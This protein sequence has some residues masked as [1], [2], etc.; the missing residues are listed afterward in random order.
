M[1]N[2]PL[3]Y[4]LAM[5][6]VPGI[7][8]ITARKLIAYVGSPE[9]VF[10]EKPE[11]LKRIPGVGAHLA[12]QVSARNLVAEAEAEIGRM[13]KYKI[14]SVYYRD[15]AYPW[16]LKNCED[17]PLLLFYRGIPDFGRTKYLSVVGTRN[18]SAYGKE[19]TGAIIAGLAAKYPDLVIVSGL[20]YGIDICAHRSALGSGLDTYAV[21]AHGL[22][23]IYPSAHAATASRM[24]S[25]GAVLSDFP[26]TMK[27]ERNNF[28]RRN[29]IIAGLSEATLVIESGKKG[30]A[31]ITAELA[32][33]YHREVFA[34]PGRTTDPYSAG[35]N[36]LIQ[37]NIAA[38]VTSDA[39]I[40]QL[41][42]W[43]TTETPPAPEPSAIHNLS[44]QEKKILQAI[45]D[46]PGLGQ[47]ILAARTGIDVHTLLGTLLQMELNQWIT[48]L[49]GNLYK[50][51]VRPAT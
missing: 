26:T 36:Q 18:A 50:A 39:D 10:S 6:M 7:G 20:A 47:E 31:L 28:L 24:L 30:G 32:A 5:T 42:G 14:S 11:T 27:P 1:S 51:L 4:Q 38:L 43:E 12:G 22:H 3:V 23:T 40:E 45:I 33:S 46:A 37:Q 35:C 13:K 44:P 25:Q 8:A 9:A 29:R 16:R 41:L 34:V 17:G 21:M 2:D 15:D 48:V 19:I 49:P